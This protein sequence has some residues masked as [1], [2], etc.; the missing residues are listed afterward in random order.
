[1]SASSRCR[2]GRSIEP[3]EK[4]PSSIGCPDQRPALVRLALDVGLGRLALGVERVEVLLQPL[5]GGDPGVD[6]AAQRA[7]AGGSV[8]M[9][10]LPSR[11]G[12]AGAEEARPVPAGAG[13][14]AGH[15]GQAAIG[16][17]VPGEAVVERHDTVLHAGPLAHQ[18]RAGPDLPG[19][20]QRQGDRSVLRR[21]PLPGE[22]VEVADAWPCRDRRSASACRR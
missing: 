10:C 18:Q 1:M 19:A 21:C 20:G 11:L 17:A 5:V 12:L 7:C 6:G 4:P 13:D 2:A 22:L 14:G 9:A 15:L 3:P 16:G 8:F